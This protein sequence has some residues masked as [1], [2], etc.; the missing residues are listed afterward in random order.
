VN[1][2]SVTAD[3]LEHAL[4]LILNGVAMR[5]ALPTRKLRAVVG[6]DQFQPSRHRSL[7]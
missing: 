3:T 6:N 2:H 4:E 1:A 5:L 7:N